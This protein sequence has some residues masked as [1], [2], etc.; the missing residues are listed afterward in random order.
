VVQL[1][2]SP[3]AL[4]R[5]RSY[6]PPVTRVD[7]ATRARKARQQKHKSNAPLGRTP[8]V[9][10]AHSHT[11]T[12]LQFHTD[13]AL[14]QTPTHTHTHTFTH[15]CTHVHTLYA[16]THIVRTHTPP[17]RSPSVSYVPAWSC[18]CYSLCLCACVCVCVS[19]CVCLRL[20]FSARLDSRD[21]RISRLIGLTCMTIMHHTAHEVSHG[22]RHL[23]AG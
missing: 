13:I 1:S 16:F 2:L 9:S 19:V 17:E 18:A 14:T 12:H 10:S 11:H 22:R 23:C 7:F 5:H 3:L 4:L 8:S 20:L 6:A 21:S 15:K